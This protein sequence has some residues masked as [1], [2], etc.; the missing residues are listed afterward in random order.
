[1]MMV[2]INQLVFASGMG[3]SPG[4]A[5]AAPRG[6]EKPKNFCKLVLILMEHKKYKKAMEQS[7]GS[8][9]CKPL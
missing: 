2:I 3:K 1:M 8:S 6:G 4:P 5:A 9:P 7:V